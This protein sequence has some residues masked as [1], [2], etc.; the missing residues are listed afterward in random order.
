MVSDIPN[1]FVKEAETLGVSEAHALP[2]LP[3]L[4]TGLA[5]RHLRSIPSDTRSGGVTCWPKVA[6]HFLRT[7]ATPVGIC[8]AINDLQNIHRKPQ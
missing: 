5:E 4:L 8:H 2:V 7:Y 3:T 1:R 6:N